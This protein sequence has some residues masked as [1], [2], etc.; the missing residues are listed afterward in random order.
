VARKT[1]A[2][3][4]SQKLLCSGIQDIQSVAGPEELK[5]SQRGKING[6]LELAPS[7]TWVGHYDF[8]AIR[9]AHR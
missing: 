4:M 3:D 1:E 7:K 5:R 9:E 6:L 2:E 8:Q